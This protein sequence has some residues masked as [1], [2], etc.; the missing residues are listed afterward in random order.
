MKILITGAT[1][2]VGSCLVT[3]LVSEGHEIN[4]LTRDISSAKK[5]FD[6]PCN[7]FS[8][9]PLSSIPPQ[10]SF[11]DVNAV[12]N[13]MGENISGGRWTENQKD[14]IFNSR[15]IGTRNLVQGIQKYGDSIETIVS[16]SAVGIYSKNTLE[17]LSEDS[18]VD[19]DFLAKVCHSWEQEL[20]KLSIRKVI[21]RVGVVLGLES[22]ALAKL[23]PIFRLGLGGPIGSG[24][25][26][27]SWIHLND[28]VDLYTEAVTNNS[29]NGTYNATAPKTCTNLEFTKALGNSLGMPAFFPVP[30]IMLK[31]LFGDMSSIIL[32]SQNVISNKLQSHG[33]KFQYPTIDEALNNLLKKKRDDGELETVHK[34]ESY[35]FIDKPLE[36]VFNFFSNPHNL[37]KITPH[38]INFRVIEMTTEKIQKDTIIEYRLNKYEIPMKWKSLI[39][40]WNP[41]YKFVDIQEYGPYKYWHHT[42]QFIPIKNGTIIVD[43]VN[44]TLPLGPLGDIAN[45]LFVKKDIQNIFNFRKKVLGNIFK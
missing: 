8:W 7:F 28:L 17:E 2:F 18:K 25:A 39:S 6:I 32:D 21:L 29:M 26:S 41:P 23:L 20:T 16:T 38:D 36:E 4:L 31:I 24:K 40:E 5:K 19:D 12:I 27:M 22:G 37:K 13:L 1:G 9:D 35:Q 14:K 33:F 42:H 34:L 3:K 43:K 45:F 44:Y 30:P 11:K 10:E 15:V